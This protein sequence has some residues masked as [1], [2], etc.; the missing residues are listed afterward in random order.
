VSS[1]S[2]LGSNGTSLLSA[3]SSDGG[4]A[5]RRSTKP[6]P[7]QY[8]CDASKYDAGESAASVL[9]NDTVADTSTSVWW[10]GAK[11]APGTAIT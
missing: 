9:R 7:T 5:A 10:S 4:V 6:A 1:R 2:T 8:P 3:G 11:A